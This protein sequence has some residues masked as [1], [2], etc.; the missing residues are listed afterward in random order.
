[1]S[2]PRALW[3]RDLNRQLFDHQFAAHCQLQKHC[4]HFIIFEDRFI[5]FVKSCSIS[6]QHVSIV[7]ALQWSSTALFLVKINLKSMFFHSHWKLLCSKAEHSHCCLGR[8][9]GAHLYGTTQEL[10]M[11]FA[12]LPEVTLLSLSLFYRG[13]YQ[14][15]PS[16]LLGWNLSLLIWFHFPRFINSYIKIFF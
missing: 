14:N 9:W 6:T 8:K 16:S 2:C 15:T 12:K 13:L 3:S 11:S 5:R 1:M 10:L 4:I 7:T